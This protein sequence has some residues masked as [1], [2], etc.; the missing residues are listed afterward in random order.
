MEAYSSF[1]EVFANHKIIREKINLSLWRN[2][3]RK[4]KRY[5]ATGFHAPIEIL[6]INI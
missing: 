4:A 1:E 5:D 2:K 3:E 6:A